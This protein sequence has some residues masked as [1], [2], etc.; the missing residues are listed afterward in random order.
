MTQTEVDRSIITMRALSVWLFLALALAFAGPVVAQ[1]LTFTRQVVIGKHQPMEL[2]LVI[3]TANGTRPPATSA[4]YQ[5]AMKHSVSFLDDTIAEYRL[6]LKENRSLAA[7]LFTWGSYFE[8]GATEMVNLHVIEANSQV[9]IALN[10]AMGIVNALLPNVQKSIPAPDPSVLVRT[11][12]LVMDS[13]GSLSGLFWA[14]PSGVQGFI[15]T[16]PQ[17]N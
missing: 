4:V 12:K 15:D 7:R 17:T 6:N 13:Q 9:S 1:Q 14:Q 16:V 10:V 2:W 3:G 5:L 11:G 8:L